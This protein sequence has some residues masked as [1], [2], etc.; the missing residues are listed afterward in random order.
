VRKSKTNRAVSALIATAVVIAGCS[1]SDDDDTSPTT[2]APTPETTEAA[3]ET[4][5]AGLSGEGLEIGLLAPSPGLL[6]G[7]FQGQVRGSALAAADVDEAGGVLDG[8]LTITSYPGEPGAEPTE[9]VQAAVDGGAQALIGPAGSDAA[10]TVRDEVASLGSIACSAS[11]TLPRITL[12]QDAMSLFRTAL[13]DDITTTYLTTA[14]TARRDAEAPGAAWNV[15]IVGRTD[16]YGLSISNGLAATIQASGM[17]PTVIGYNPRR[18]NFAGTAQQVA[19]AAPDLT[20]LV[21]YEEGGNLLSS[22]TS[23]GLN[24]AAMVGLDAFFTP[25]IAELATPG[26]GD[27]AAV[28]GFTMLGSLGNKAFL[29]RLYEDDSNAQVSNAPQAYDCAVTL[30]LATAAVDAGSSD[31]ISEAVRDVT[32]GGVTCT[33][34]ADCLDKLNAGE[35]IDFDG[36]S[37]QLAIDEN[38]DPTFARFTT[39]VLRGGVIS[40]LSSTDINIADIRR[41]Q[42]AYAAAAQITKIQQA[43]T[44]LG[45]Y[46]GPINGLDT[47]EFRAALAAFQTS[48]GLP[49][50]GVFDEATDAALRAAL[51]EYA[52]LLSATTA[53]IQRLMTELGFYTGPIDGVWTEELTQAIKELQAELGVPQTGVLDAAT[54]RAIYAAGQESGAATTTT[55]PATTAPE[56]TAPETTAP[57]TTV[58]ATTVPATTAPPTTAPPTTAPETTLPPVDPTLPTLSEALQNAPEFSD[59][60]RLLQAAAFPDDFDQLQAY[61]LFAPTN[62]ALAEA[63]YDIDAIIADVDPTL[64]FELLAD[65]VALGRLELGD[66]PDPIEMLSGNEFPVTN[67]GTTVTINGQAIVGEPIRAANG[68]IHGLGSLTPR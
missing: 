13:P 60:V 46:S 9:N 63:G 17:V 8:P 42:A 40:D 58:P 47:P 38:G 39:A 5:E 35:D 54:L 65:T 32:D 7:L 26:G 64:L 62:D 15:A 25:R 3:P 59:Y 67:D 52:D 21:T 1:S 20:V 29:E 44:F 41:Q 53:D 16:E 31:T 37:G 2:Q 48:V 50:T 61:T 45:F 34:Y 51:G 36:V 22:L 68:I 4:T 19:A 11:A 6:A 28:D 10:E 66:L 56:T 55:V 14:I 27:A 57:A 23:A 12:E 49:P 30:A 33:T 18:V 43:L 24:P